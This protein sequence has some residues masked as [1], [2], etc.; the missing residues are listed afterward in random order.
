[1]KWCDMHLQSPQN[2][3]PGVKDNLVQQRANLGRQME[4]VNNQITMYRVRDGTEIC[5]Q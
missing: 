3:R 4:L 2:N 5:R 1:M